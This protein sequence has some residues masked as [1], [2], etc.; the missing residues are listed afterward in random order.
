MLTN[1]LFSLLTNSKGDTLIKSKNEIIEELGLNTLNINEYEGKNFEVYK[2]FESEFE[3]LI[4]TNAELYGIEPVIFYIDNS[5]ICNAFA[6]KRNGYNI[7]G[8][9]KGYPILF[10]DKFKE[11][12]FDSL[13]FAAFLNNG[14]V[15]DGFASLYK[16][17][18]FSFSK[19]MLDCSIHFTFYHE[20]RHLLQFNVIKDKTDNHLAENCFERP[21]D[22]KKHILEY[23]ADKSAA[24]KV[25]L[26]A[27]SV[28]RKFGF[29]TDGE[30]LALIYCALGSLFITRVLFNYGLVGQWQEPLKPNPM[31]FYTK[32]NWHPH[33]AIRALNLL[34]SFNVF[35]SDGYPHLKIETQKLITNSMGITKL[36]LDK[37]LPNVDTAGLIFGD[38]FSEIEKS[39]EYNNYL[40]NEALS[41]PIIQKLIDKS[42]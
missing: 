33:P 18:N 3:K 15:S 16:N 10:G 21:F 14:N 26:Y 2:Y 7:M 6:T 37:L 1:K 12:F 25:V 23:D 32:K 5:T 36:Y 42:L 29:R 17:E 4:S 38:M 24:N 40:H 35:I 41:D 9:T 30:F 31:K 28:L 11:D 8:I 19:F 39:N 34:D 22:L 20:F 13:I 27:A